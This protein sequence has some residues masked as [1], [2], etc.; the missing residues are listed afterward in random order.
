MSHLEEKVKYIISGTNRPGSR[1]RQVSNLIQK[2]YAE[3]GEKVEILDLTDLPFAELTG[4]NYSGAGLHLQWSEAVQKVTEA[5]AL[6][7]VVPEYNGSMPGALKYFID[8][9]KYPESFEFRPVCFVG[10]GGLFGGLRPIEHLQQVM[11]FRNAFQFPARVFL[12]NIF[13]TLKDGELVEPIALQLLK[14]QVQ[15]FQKFVKALQ[16]QGLDANAV[17]KQRPKKA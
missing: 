8:H 1:T 6:I 7:F 4:Q 16:S 9:W 3:Q 17:N 10:L 12:M 15:G 2:L 14:D 11:A 13:K 5:E